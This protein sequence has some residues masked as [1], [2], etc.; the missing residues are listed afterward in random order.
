MK[1]GSKSESERDK[2]GHS[3]YETVTSELCESGNCG[4]K[5]KGFSSAAK[6]IFGE[7]FFVFGG[8][9][10]NLLIFGVFCCSHSLVPTIII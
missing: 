1:P 3:F 10:D 9:A 2:K 8:F 7:R 4:K 6:A 5:K